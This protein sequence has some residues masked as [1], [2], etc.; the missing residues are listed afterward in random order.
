MNV[1]RKNNAATPFG[2]AAPVSVALPYNRQISSSR[3]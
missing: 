2:A 3:S 1:L